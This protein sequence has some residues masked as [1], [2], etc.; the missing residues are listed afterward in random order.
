MLKVMLFSYGRTY[1][2]EKSLNQI[3]SSFSQ[4]KGVRNIYSTFFLYKNKIFDE[5]YSLL[6]K[7]FNLNHFAKD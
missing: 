2:L 3:K 7:I 6:I 1:L 4:I 5:F